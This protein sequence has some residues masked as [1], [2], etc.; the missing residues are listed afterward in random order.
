MRNRILFYLKYL[1]IAILALVIIIPLWL[2][3][4][5]SFKTPDEALGAGIGLPTQFK[6]IEN[7]SSV[8]T[9]GNIVRSFFNSLLITMCSSILI[10]FIS[11]LASYV[12]SRRK[13][14]TVRYIYYIF[15]MGLMI[16][17]SMISTVILLKYLNLVGTYLGMILF[18]AGI[19]T[20]FPIFLLTG[21]MSTI[22]KEIEESALIDGTTP[23]TT[24]FYIILP[25]LKPALATSFIWSFMA[26]W[27]DFMYPLYILGGKT[28]MY[29]ITLGIYSFKSMYNTQW[30]LL[31]AFLLIVSLPV[32]FTFIIAQRQIISGM[33]AGA[34]KG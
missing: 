24:F 11:A 3:I 6:A 14:R 1:L 20:P 21:F 7:Y 25:L 4:I 33:T 23:I 13:S 15:L 26:V 5:N 27:N 12:F 32:I 31:F 16:P 19:M 29:T 22:P 28:E 34:I 8:I 18:Y 30:N 2:I 10:I 9:K 17:A